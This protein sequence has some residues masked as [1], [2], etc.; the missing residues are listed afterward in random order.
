MRDAGGDHEAITNERERV[1]RGEP[2][3]LIRLFHRQSEAAQ[4][5]IDGVSRTGQPEAFLVERDLF[6]LG[7][8]HD[9]VLAQQ[10]LIVSIAE[11]YST[12]A[13]ARRPLLRLRLVAL[14]S[15]DL[16]EALQQGNFLGGPQGA[17]VFSITLLTCSQ[18]SRAERL[19][20]VG[21]IDGTL[22]G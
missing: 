14:A 22:Q 13:L 8:D 6:L 1:A 3:Q 5:R 16:T 2:C 21:Q 10:A 20:V 4:L 15:P 19:D 12:A 18:Q 17:Q 7:R 11:L 9:L